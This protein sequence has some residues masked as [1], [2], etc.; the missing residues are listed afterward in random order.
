MQ[1]VQARERLEKNANLLIF[2]LAVYAGVR[3]VVG[4]A[5]Q[6]F[7]IDEIIT[8]M[9]ATQPGLKGIWAALLK[10]VDS[11]PPGFYVIERLGLD[12]ASNL[13]IALRI[14][15]ILAVPITITCVFLYVK[16]RDGAWAALLCS[17]LL[18]STAQFRYFMDIARPY[19]MIV[20]CFAFALLCHQRLPSPWWTVLLALTLAFAQ[21]IHYF[22][23]L[24]IL[25]FWLSEGTFLLTRRQF[26]WA[27]WF[28]LI[29]GPLPLL[30]FW[31]LLSAFKT[32]YGG[33][34]WEHFAAADLARAYGAFFWTTTGIGVGMAAIAVTGV[35]GPRLWIRLV[36]SSQAEV[37]RQDLAED[38]LVLGILALPFIAFVVTRVMHGEM[39]ER[40][41][42]PAILGIVL[43]LGRVFS[44][45]NAKA[46]TLLTIFVLSGVGVVELS[47]WRS[48]H[49]LNVSSLTAPVEEFVEKAG[50]PELPVVV[51]N[52]I[53]YVPLVYYASP[54][55]K[56]RFV[57]L[58][59]PE[60][61]LR[62]TRTDN[63]DK[64]LRS[65]VGY[66]PIEIQTYSEFV[67]SHSSFL[68]YEDAAPGLEWLPLELSREN[69]T[70]QV[71]SIEQN[72]TLY[73]VTMKKGSVAESGR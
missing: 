9:V 6:A 24:A 12:L 23:I 60:K 2:L 66:F 51:S 41:I 72:R 3:G 19:S 4:A 42:I 73:L 63:V 40:H 17:F 50:H 32:Y 8:K 57:F 31:P 46:F 20:A 35:I 14:P 55:W 38:V 29:V 13:H 49:P 44:R 34:Y 64:A 36:D 65:F 39:L 33:H 1:I 15:S 70:M 47:F 27:V 45:A 18:L 54:A 52:G 16:K 53:T 67:R 56:H 37:S 43:G 69:A 61:A 59:D 68:L 28:A 62:Y 58:D 30:F 5:T 7:S 48:V 10:S 25:P 21:S 71:V 11:A 22:A 26:R